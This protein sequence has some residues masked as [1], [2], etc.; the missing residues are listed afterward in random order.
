[1]VKARLVNELAVA[2][3]R[4]ALGAVAPLRCSGDRVARV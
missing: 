3:T 1:L 2:E 4:F